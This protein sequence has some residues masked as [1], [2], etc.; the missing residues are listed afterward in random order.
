M[1]RAAVLV[2]CACSY[3]CAD[4]RGPHVERVTP[5]AAPHDV[6]VELLG[7]RLCLARSCDDVGGDLQIGLSPPT[8]RA[9]IVSVSDTR[10]ELQVPSLVPVGRTALVLSVDDHVSNS[11]PFEVLP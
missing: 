5:A 10:W 7:E 4:D 11:L 9:R 8:Y 6:T 2:A 3:A 1:I